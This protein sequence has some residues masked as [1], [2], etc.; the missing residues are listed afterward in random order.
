MV[1]PVYVLPAQDTQL[2]TSYPF[3][4]QLEP[5]LPF[6]DAAH[7]PPFPAAQELT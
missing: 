2:G 7:P 1:P 3:W 4:Q 5:S 6:K